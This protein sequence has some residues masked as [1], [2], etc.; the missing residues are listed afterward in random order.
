MLDKGEIE[1]LARCDALAEILKHVKSVG[2]KVHDDTVD[3]AE[4]IAEEYVKEVGCP[5]TTP[6]VFAAAC[7]YLAGILTGERLRQ[8]DVGGLFSVSEASIRRSFKHIAKALGSTV[9]ELVE[10]YV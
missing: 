7:V 9:W 8:I 4:K 1:K 5:T 10:K 6:K 3:L 2:G